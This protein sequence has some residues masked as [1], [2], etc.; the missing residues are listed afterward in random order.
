MKEGGGTKLEKKM[1]EANGLINGDKNGRENDPSRWLHKQAE[2]ERT[3]DS[4][5]G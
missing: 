5:G 3:S 1:E 2:V 4:S